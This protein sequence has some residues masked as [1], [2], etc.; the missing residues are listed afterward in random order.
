[1]IIYTAVRVA[2]VRSVTISDIE[3]KSVKRLRHVCRHSPDGFEWGY[4]GSGPSDLAL[5]IMTD[6][7]ARQG[8]LDS[9]IRADSC[10]QDFK[11]A[12]IAD[13]KGEVLSIYEDQ[14]REWL[15]GRE[16]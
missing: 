7:F 3:G 6:Y 16:Q 14:I 10:Y 13:A 5:S 9:T 4:G 2:G 1:M 8:F 12:F 15:E 11:W